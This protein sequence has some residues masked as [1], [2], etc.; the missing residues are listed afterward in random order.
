MLFTVPLTWTPSATDNQLPPAAL[1]LHRSV[2]QET[3]DVTPPNLDDLLSLAFPLGFTELVYT[4]TD[5][6]GNQ[7]SCA[8]TVEVRDV[9]PPVVTCPEGNPI[10]IASWS[11]LPTATAYDLVSPYLTRWTSAI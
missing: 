7:A 4:A 1:L 5:A 2:F 3:T 9:E 11:D 8:F 6:A 10:I